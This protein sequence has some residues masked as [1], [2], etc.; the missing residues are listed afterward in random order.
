M[1][2]DGVAYMRVLIVGA[3]IVGLSIARV[4]SMYKGLDVVVVEKEPDAGWG[5]S[6]ANTSI[7]HPG[8]EEDPDKHPLRARLC[9]EGNKLW[10]R[11][12]RELDIP[13]RWPGE[14]MVFT[15]SEEE[16]EALK[17]IDL[18]R[19]NKVPGVRNVYGDELKSLE[20]A[21]SPVALGAVYAPTAGSISP[22]DAIAALAENLVG[23]GG[24]I[25]FSTMVKG[26][27]V[28]GGVVKGVETTRGFIEADIVV[29]AAGV[30][31]DEV[32]HS[33]GVE[34][35]FTIRPRKGEY[36]VFDEDTAVKPLRLLHTT[37]T[38]LTKGVY[39]ITTTGGDLMIG[40]TAVDLPSE[41]KE[42]TSTTHEAVEYLLREAGKLLREVPS[43]SAAIRTF[44]GVRPEPPNGEWLIK[45][46]EEPWGFVNVAGIRSPGLTAAPAIAYYVADLISRN[47]GVRLEPKGEWKPYRRGIT[48]IRGKT[49]EEIDKLVS[50]NP[51]YG[52]VVCYCRM[53]SKA[54][55]LE[56]I[57]RIKA[58]GA[59][60]TLDGIRFRTRAGFGRCQGSFCRWRIAEIIARL[61]GVEIHEVVVK[62]GQYGIGDVKKLLRE[63]V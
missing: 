51:D 11:W 47:Y 53:V 34:E 15:S 4:L 21:V 17:Y 12:V 52:E 61:E 56:A 3:G 60:V 57:E 24:R 41:L 50:S 32:S 48:R 9:V 20:P 6:K 29:N 1:H 62:R 25:L 23:N 40:P 13:S 26:V 28:E 18:A 63:G 22:F 55:V 8:H 14:L 38:G 49:L 10:R 33:A 16:K 27:R 59:Q 42:D 43:R 36:I 5:A 19:R 35:S 31:A 58:I 45:T 44:A 39:A 30:H 54:E 2:V 46:Y 7:I 37:P